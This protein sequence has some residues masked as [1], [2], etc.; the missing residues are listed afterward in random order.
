MD[1]RSNKRQFVLK[2]EAA[3]SQAFTGA[4]LGGYE[5]ARTN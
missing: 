1:C 4:R 5:S 2:K 3:E